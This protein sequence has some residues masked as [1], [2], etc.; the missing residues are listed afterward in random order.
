MFIFFW[1]LMVYFFVSNEK[2]VNL[3]VF[4]IGCNEIQQDYIMIFCNCVVVDFGVFSG[5]VMLV[6]YEC[7]CCSLML[8][9]IYCFNNGLYSQNGYVIW[10]V[11]SLESVICFGLNKVCEEGICIDSIGIDIWGVDFVLFD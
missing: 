11:D 7:E 2:V 5:C 6:C 3:G 4:Q 9:E 8:C 10:D 1:L